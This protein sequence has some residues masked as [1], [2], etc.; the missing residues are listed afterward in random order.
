MTVQSAQPWNSA[1]YS[2]QNFSEYMY[3]EIG[4]PCASATHALLE[5]DLAEATDFSKHDYEQPVPFQNETHE[6]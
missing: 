4:N 1:L 6:W 5:V 2:I 3:E